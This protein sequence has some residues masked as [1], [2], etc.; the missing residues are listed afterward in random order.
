MIRKPLTA[1]SGFIQLVRLD[2]RAHRPIEDDDARLQ[3]F[4]ERVRN[5]HVR[6]GQALISQQSL[7]RDSQ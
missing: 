7:E 6:Q 1:E 3:N 2:H 4:F 5:S